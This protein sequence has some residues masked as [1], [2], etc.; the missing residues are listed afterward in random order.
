MTTF[1]GIGRFKWYFADV[2]ICHNGIQYSKHGLLVFAPK[3]V[4]KAP[5]IH[6][7]LGN[8]IARTH[9]CVWNDSETHETV[10]LD[11]TAGEAGSAIQ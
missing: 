8:Y 3:D 5:D 9:G 7:A 6:K 10:L 1:L 2:V 4:S 11:C